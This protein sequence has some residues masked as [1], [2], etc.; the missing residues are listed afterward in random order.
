MASCEFGREFRL[1]VEIRKAFGAIAGD[2]MLGCPVRPV[3]HVIVNSKPL[4]RPSALDIC[5][6]LKPSGHVAKG[7]ERCWVH[8]VN[9]AV[10]GPA[11]KSGSK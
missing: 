10:I 3:Q 4:A 6:H 7:C 2:K 9:A 1:Y 5:P 8:T 11:D